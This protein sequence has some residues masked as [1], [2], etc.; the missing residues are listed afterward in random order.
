MDQ[1]KYIE[2]I[3]QQLSGE[4]SKSDEKL[5]MEWV[6]SNVENQA[7]WDETKQLWEISDNFDDTFDTDVDAAW[8]NVEQKIGGNASSNSK[9]VDINRAKLNNDS[10]V[11]VVGISKFKRLLQ[12]AAVL[13]MA[14]AGWVWLNQGNADPQLYTYQ[15]SDDEK[16]E[17]TLPDQSQVVLNENSQ[18]AFQ[19]VDGKRM[20]NLEGEA[21]F[22]VKH[23]ADVPFEILSGDAKTRVLGTAFNVRAY[24]QEDKIEVS[25]E[26][27]LVAFSENENV[28]NKTQLPA[29]TEGIFY[30][31]QKKIAKEKRADDNVDAW[32]TKILIFENTPMD[33]VVEALER[34]YEVEI[35][36][37]SRILKCELSKGRFENTTLNKVLETI[38]FALDFES[39]IDGKKIT[40]TGEGC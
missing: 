3:A 17:I 14:G 20:V 30:K 40:I 19:E 21:W 29:G 31:K 16:L 33:K 6:A 22:D 18:L 1:N 10:S 38:D 34:Y 11:K 24:P 5:L 32:R 2:L 37:N 15:T 25:V 12:Y 4:I 8:M 35:T 36:A 7:L 23:L 9:V 13:L 26:R 39:S 28:E 27:G